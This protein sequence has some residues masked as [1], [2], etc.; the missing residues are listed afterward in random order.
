VIAKEEQKIRVKNS[1]PSPIQRGWETIG[2]TLTDGTHA[3]RRNAAWSGKT[4]PSEMRCGLCMA[5]HYHMTECENRS[6]TT[7]R[8]LS[9]SPGGTWKNPKRDLHW[10]RPSGFLSR[11]NG[12]EKYTERQV[13]SEGTLPGRPCQLHHEQRAWVLV[14]HFQFELFKPCHSS[15]QGNTTDPCYFLII[16]SYIHTCIHSICPCPRVVQGPN[17]LG[18]MDV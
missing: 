15:H 3:D 4:L 10:E 8:Q 16:I 12:L 18:G 6:V 1:L 11:S 5:H 9:S 2:H 17:R 13:G 14:E 7:C